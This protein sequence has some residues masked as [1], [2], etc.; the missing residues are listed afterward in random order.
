MH[1]VFWFILLIIFVVV[2]AVTVN[3]VSAWFAAGSLAAMLAAMTEFFATYDNGSED[4]VDAI[5]NKEVSFGI[6]DRE[7]AQAN[8]RGARK[9]GAVIMA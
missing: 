6:S 1:T 2:E 5:N 3:M 8:R 9:L 7:I 4:I